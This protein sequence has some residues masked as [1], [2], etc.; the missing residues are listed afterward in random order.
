VQCC[1]HGAR[2]YHADHGLHTTAAEFISTHYVRGISDE[3]KRV[4][5]FLLAEEPAAHIQRSTVWLL[6][7]EK[8]LLT[9]RYPAL[10]LC[11]RLT[12][13]SVDRPSCQL[14]MPPSPLCV[15][16]VRSAVGPL[17]VNTHYA[18]RGISVLSGKTW[19]RY[20]SFEWALLRRFSRSNVKSQGHSQ[21]KCIF[22]G[23]GI[24]I[25]GLLSIISFSCYKVFHSFRERRNCCSLQP[26]Y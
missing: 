12:G 17:S 1:V 10:R 11:L 19:H 20:S 5:S 2:N 4:I 22:F 14:F 16:V 3:W 21:A 18:R 8:R 24:P 15:Q 23:K 26:V 13:G 25:N 9:L 6:W 7:G